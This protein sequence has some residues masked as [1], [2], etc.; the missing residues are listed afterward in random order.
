MVSPNIVNREKGSSHP[1][2]PGQYYKG[3]VEYVDASGRVTVHVKALGATFG[4]VA[5][6]GVTT[7]NKLQKNDVV[8]CTFTDEFFTELV[9][10]GSSKIKA[11]VFASKTV[12]ENL[13]S[14]IT[15]L[16]NQIVVLNQ[17]VTA[18]ENA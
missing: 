16:Q 14:T 10:F 4:P 5:P 1:L 2:K 9:V 8:T 6:V 7:L 12:V 17:R 18:L 13:L 15:S 11:D 3:S